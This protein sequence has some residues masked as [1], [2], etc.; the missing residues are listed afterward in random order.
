[1]FYIVW[2][3]AVSWA[4]AV[5]DIPEPYLI[6]LR[7]FLNMILFMVILIA[8]GRV[9]RMLLQAGSE[10]DSRLRWLDPGSLPLFDN[11]LKVVLIALGLYLVLSAWNLDV[12]PWLASAGIA[13]IAIGFAAKDTLANLFGGMFILADA[14]YRIG[15]YIVLG[16][17]ERG[18]VTHIGLRST[19]ILTRDDVEITI[20][21]AM[22]A[23]STIINE[24]GGPSPKFRVAMNVGVSYGA[25]IGLV[26]KILLGVAS[27]S[28][29]VAKDPEPRVRFTLF[30]DSALEFRL[31]CWVE[32]P[33]LRGLCLH[34]MHTLTLVRFRENGVEIPFPQ[35]VMHMPGDGSGA[36]E[37]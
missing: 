17:G 31:L 35:R 6:W 9:I 11:L 23:N 4:I 5:L 37:S 22:I 13:G 24:S 2:L 20:P 14:P 29:G 21:N 12:K 1:V 10:S 18:S 25:D 34:H 16:T 8:A 15:D 28:P 3:I 36:D 7:S 19:R 27:D 30:G 33:A 32:D 26:E